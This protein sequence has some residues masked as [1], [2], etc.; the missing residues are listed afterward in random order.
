MRKGST[1]AP[2]NIT[3]PCAASESSLLP[4]LVEDDEDEVEVC[5][6]EEDVVE[7]AVPFNLSAFR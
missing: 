3:I 1:I 2:P 6:L 5:L 7:E 4:V